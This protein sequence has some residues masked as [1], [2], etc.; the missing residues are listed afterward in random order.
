MMIEVAGSSETSVHLYQATRRH[1]PTY[2]PFI[3]VV[4]LPYDMSI[5]RRRKNYYFVWSVKRDSLLL[6]CGL[7]VDAINSSLC[8][9]SDSRMASD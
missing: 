4:V 8:M 5:S 3:T 6:T 7:F 9:T 1:V 2:G